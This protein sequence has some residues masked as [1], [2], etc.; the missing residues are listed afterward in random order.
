MSFIIEGGLH[1]LNR[2]EVVTVGTGDLPVIP[3]GIQHASRT[4]AERVGHAVPDARRRAL[5]LSVWR[6]GSDEGASPQ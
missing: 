5:P 1:V 6:N 4:P 3:P 2:V